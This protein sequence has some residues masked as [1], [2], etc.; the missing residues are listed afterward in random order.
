MAFNVYYYFISIIVGRFAHFEPQ[1]IARH[2]SLLGT[3]ITNCKSF[4]SHELFSSLIPLRSPKSIGGKYASEKSL[5]V[6]S[7]PVP[8]EQVGVYNC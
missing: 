3:T 5:S 1:S 2:F 4:T 8:Q 6:S 7:N